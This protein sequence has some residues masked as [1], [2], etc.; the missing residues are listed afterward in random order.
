MKTQTL[1]EARSH[2][3]TKDIFDNCGQT[4]LCGE[5]GTRQKRKVTLLEDRRLTR[6]YTH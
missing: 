2:T 4:N 5:Q 6:L 1:F 3:L